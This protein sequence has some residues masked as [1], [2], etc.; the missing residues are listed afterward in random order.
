MVFTL[1]M[2]QLNAA[3]QNSLD[4]LLPVWL[5]AMG[6]AVAA[7]VLSWGLRTMRWY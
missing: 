1:P 4:S 3:I 2:S 5:L 7:Y 6:M